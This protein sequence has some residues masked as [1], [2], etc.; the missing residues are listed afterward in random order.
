MKE[1]SS[2]RAEILKNAT[3]T[4]TIITTIVIDSIVWTTVTLINSNWGWFRFARASARLV[5][6]LDIIQQSVPPYRRQRNGNPPRLSH[7]LTTST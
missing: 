5:R 3:N 4:A 2:F 6:P 1:P 7:R